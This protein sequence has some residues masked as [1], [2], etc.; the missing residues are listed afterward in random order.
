LNEGREAEVLSQLERIVA[1]A[2]VLSQDSEELFGR[3]RDGREN[4]KYRRKIMIAPLLT[5]TT[6]NQGS[7]EDED[8]CST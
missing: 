5:G 1:S 2:D 7:A 3:I 6:E 4:G 8:N